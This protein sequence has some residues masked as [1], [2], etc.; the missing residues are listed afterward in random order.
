MGWPGLAPR[1]L[2]LVDLFPGMTYNL[3][4]SVLRIDTAIPLGP[5]KVMIEFRGLGLKSDTPEERAAARPR[6]QHDLGTVR[7]QPARGPARRPR[8][9]P[10]DAR[11]APTAAGCSTAARRT[12]TIHDEVGMRH[13]Y[14]E[15]SRSAWAG[16]LTTLTGNGKPDPVA[17][18]CSDENR[19]KAGDRGP[20][21]PLVPRTRRRRIS[22]RSSSSATRSSATRSPPTARRSARRWSGS[23][24]TARGMETLFTNLPRHNSD[25]SPLSAPCDGLHRR[26]RKASGRRGGVGPAG[27]Q[28]AARRRRD[29]AFRGWAF[30]RHGEARRR[31]GQADKR[32]VRLETRQ[33]GYGYHIPF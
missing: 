12:C 15:W 13:F 27:V 32:V 11:A 5:N 4:T 6:P 25:H 31:I 22:R 24:T 14:A 23:T 1:R 19:A 20:C 10:G 16:P 30:H 26:R 18:R 28:D 29:R 7:P 33:L 9:G 17:C 21:L 3:R 2:V 8:P